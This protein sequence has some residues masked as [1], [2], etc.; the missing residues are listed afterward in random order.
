M[1]RIVCE[2]TN[3]CNLSCEHCFTGR[4]GGSDDLPL[5]V[6]DR[7][8]D[9]ARDN[10]FNHLSFTGDDPTVHPQFPEVLR[11]T[12]EAGYRFSFVTNG[13]N[14]SN[15]YPRLLPHFG[16]LDVITFSLDGATEAS[17]DRLRGKGS[18]RRALKSMSI[19]VVKKIPFTINMVITRHN[20]H[21]LETMADIATRLGC[22][23]LRFGHLMPSFI[24][25][26][27]NFDLS[28]IE[29]KEVEAEVR[30]L[31]QGSDIPIAMAVGIHTTS[32]FPCDPLNMQEINVDCHGN[33]T[34]CCHL[35]GHGD[36]VGD[37]DLMGNLNEESFTTLFE[38]QN[39]ENKRFRE[40]KLERHAAGDLADSDYFP[41]WYCSVY[42]QKVDWL[43][44][45]KGHSWAPLIRDQNPQSADRKA[46]TVAVK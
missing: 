25:T 21:E 30:A 46:E 34:K 42:Y 39:E 7:I 10:G 18:Y 45:F 12:A 14:F 3:R 6:L 40:E 24:T 36:G 17:H 8:L 41:C 32:L 9:E 44:K 5:G 11:R 19:C 29:R 28:P 43:R 4:H 1:A 37:D 13:W 2:L 16:N 22:R 20:R 26:V 27:Q 33:V 23:G 38:R 35:S 31:A 15:I